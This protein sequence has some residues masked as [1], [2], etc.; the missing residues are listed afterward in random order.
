MLDNQPLLDAQ[1]ILKSDGVDG[2][3]TSPEELHI[4]MILSDVHP[5]EL[6]NVL[7]PSET[8]FSVVI[9]RID[10]FETDNGYAIY[11]R[12]RK[13]GVLADTQRVM[14]NALINADVEVAAH[15][16]FENWKPHITLLYSEKPIEPYDIDPVA[17]V[18]DE[19]TVFDEEHNPVSKLYLKS[20]TAGF[21]NSGGDMETERQYYFGGAAKAVQNNRVGGYLVRFTD[22]SKKDLEGEYFTPETEFYINI[23]DGLLKLKTLY[24]HGFKEGTKYHDVGHFV[25]AKQ[26]DIGLWVEAEIDMSNRYA[27]AIMKLVDEG[28]LGWSSGAIP[29]SVKVA[30]DG[31]ITEWALVEGSLTVAPAMPFETKIHSQKSLNALLLREGN[32]DPIEVEQGETADADKNKSTTMENTEMNPEELQAMIAEVVAKQLKELGVTPADATAMTDEVV[33]DVKENMPENPEAMDVEKVAK[34]AS[35]KTFELFKKWT[36]QKGKAEAAVKGAM[37]SQRQAWEKQQPAEYDKPGVKS[38]GV[39]TGVVDRR[40]DHWD[41]EDFSY[42]AELNKAQQMSG[43]GVSFNDNFWQAF[44]HKVDSQ[45]AGKSY[46]PQLIQLARAIK[47]GAVKANELNHSTQSGYGDEHVPTAWR[48][49]IWRKARRD[50]VVAP[51]FNVMEMPSNPYELPVEGTD[52][53]V[54]FVGETTNEDQLLLSGSGSAIPD[55]KVG[56]A[57]VTLT[58]KKLALRVGIASELEEDA[59]AGTIPLYR[60]QAERAILNSIDHVLLNGDTAT[61]NNINLD[62]GSAAAPSKYFAMDGLIKHALV[63]VSANAS[64]HSGA[65]PTLAAIR[66]ARFLLDRSKQNVSDLA[67][68]THPEVEAKLLGMDEFLTMDKAG[69]RATNMNGQIGVIDGIPVFISNE[70]DLSDADGKITS[71]G[72]AVN[73]GRLLIVHRPSWY[74]GYRRRIAANF[75]YLSYYDSW[76]LTVT[77]RFA[78][79]AQS[80]DDA[81]ILYNIGV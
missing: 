13:I 45:N 64:D 34:M 16:A 33:G 22:A 81:S 42:A 29:P 26:D 65:S 24:N 67:I 69:N 57:K 62:G 30:S 3:W 18:V 2:K 7:P 43:K 80:N 54:Y 52:P 40:Y 37:E 71:G 63:T 55:S 14:L 47:S 79:T 21:F 58:A 77:V 49:E 20:A 66:K 48:E 11:A 46:D 78:F 38:G 10:Q 39:I 27:A 6:T 76:Q 23:P 51:L 28:R 75:D 56:S 31:R 17:L 35:E 9:D 32:E 61:S 5:N 4:T 70:L 72:N 74:I 1:T 60:Q 12:V 44:A 59:V 15:S 19:I 41:V 53:S 36:D 50:N 73:R 8:A 68:I 25:S